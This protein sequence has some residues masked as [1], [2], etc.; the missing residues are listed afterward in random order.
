MDE[1]LETLRTILDEVS[2]IETTTK[3]AHEFRYKVFP[4]ME[5]LRIPA[6]KLEMLVDEK[7]WP[8][9]TYGDLLFYV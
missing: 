3:Q 1:A 9:P 8:I 5:A 7:K 6:D 4:A 2:K